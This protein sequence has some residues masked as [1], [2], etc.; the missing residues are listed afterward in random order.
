MHQPGQE[1]L[2]RDWATRI[3]LIYPII[4]HHLSVTL[5]HLRQVL[6]AYSETGAVILNRLNRRSEDLNVVA[7]FLME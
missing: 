7:E 5:A 4:P 1:I 6:D 2:I 3:V